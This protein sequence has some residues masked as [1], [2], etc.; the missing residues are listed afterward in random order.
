MAFYTY[1]VVSLRFA[2]VLILGMVSRAYMRWGAIGARL[3]SIVY[4]EMC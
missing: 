1:T 2:I 3:D 4:R